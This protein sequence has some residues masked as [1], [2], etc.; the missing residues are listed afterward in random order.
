SHPDSIAGSYTE[1]QPALDIADHLWHDGPVCFNSG[2]TEI[3]INRTQIMH[4]KG[5][6]EPGHVRTH[7]LKIFTSTLK[8]GKWVV[9]Q[10]FFLNNDQYSVG[11]PALSPDGATLY[12]V[13]DMPGGYG[14]TDIYVC[15]RTGDTWSPAVNL[16]ATVNTPGKEMFPFI[17]ANG[18]LYF[19]SDG[20]PGFG[21]LDLFVTRK[22]EKGWGVPRN[23]GQPIN[24][25][26]DD[27]SIAISSAEN[28]LF[29]SN[30]P[31]GKG[32]DDIYGFY[33]IVPEPVIPAPPPIATL[34]TGIP[35]PPAKRTDTLVPDKPYR[36]ENIFYDF[37]K[38][39]IRDDAKPALDNLVSLMK[40]FPISVELSSHTDCRGS[41]T[42]NLELSQKRAESAVRY[43]ISQG[44]AP[45]RITAKGYGK[46][47]PANSCNCLPGSG[48]TE[49][50]HQ[51]NRRTEFMVTKIN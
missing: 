9:P 35:T 21:G 13:S 33:K 4:D 8:E 26:F 28:G 10:P 50:E 32:S 15:Q 51:F 14:E 41:E 48:C 3:F 44:I 39:N 18:D 37:D 49:A 29:S 2:F 30:R 36:L 24:S 45:N 23:L 43:I 1:P 42:Y 6:R 17:A 11:H 22:G 34:Y 20:L 40:K 47:R 16:G 38:W 25:S 31:G 19:S 46:S 12:F 27:F 7:L 5:K